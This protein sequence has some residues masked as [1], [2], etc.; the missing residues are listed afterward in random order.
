MSNT[1]MAAMR[2]NSLR[3]HA[4]ILLIQGESHRLR[5]KRKIGTATQPSTKNE[6]KGV[7]FYSADLIAMRVTFQSTLTAQSP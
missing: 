7:T 6:P 1:S 2:L 4:H 5:N 3:F